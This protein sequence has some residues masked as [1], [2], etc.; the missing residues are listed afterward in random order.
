MS[1]HVQTIIIVAGPAGV[2]KTRVTNAL[3][4]KTPIWLIPDAKHYLPALPPAYWAGRVE[5]VNTVIVNT[6]G[7]LKDCLIE[8]RRLEAKA[9]EILAIE[10]QSLTLT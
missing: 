7:S 3:T 4:L 6:T 9:D 8:L 2:G 10:V 5:V 1:A